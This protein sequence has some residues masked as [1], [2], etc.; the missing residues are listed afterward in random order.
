MKKNQLNKFHV[1]I[2]ISELNYVRF[3]K[4]KYHTVCVFRGK[5][6][7][8]RSHIFCCEIVMIN[9]SSIITQKSPN[10]ENISP[11]LAE[12]SDISDDVVLFQWLNWKN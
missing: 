12:Y 6:C 1:N 10:F 4:T 9:R 7:M 8:H 5:N 11:C 3:A 2:C